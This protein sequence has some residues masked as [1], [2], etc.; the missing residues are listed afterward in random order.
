MKNPKIGFIGGGNM[1]GAMIEALWRAQSDEAGAV[2]SSAEDERKSSGGSEAQRA[3]NLV[4]TD[5]APRPREC[6]KRRNLKS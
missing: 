2:R 1:G 6:E 4:Q 3:E 5:K